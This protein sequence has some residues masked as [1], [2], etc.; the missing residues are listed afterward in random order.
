MLLTE[1]VLSVAVGGDRGG[2]S[3]VSGMGY[4]IERRQ[5]ERCHAHN[6]GD[7]GETIGT[8]GKAI[9]RP[10]L[11]HEGRRQGRKGLTDSKSAGPVE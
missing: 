6:R 5:L 2:L 10:C 7:Q 8:A 9:R 11:V 3:D 1:E 4:K